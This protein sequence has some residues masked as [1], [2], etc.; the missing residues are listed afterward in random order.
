RS[1]AALAAALGGWLL[2]RLIRAF[3]LPDAWAV[4]LEPLARWVGPLE[5]VALDA[6]ELAVA[7]QWI[8]GLALAGAVAIALLLLRGFLLASKNATL[9]DRLAETSGELASVS[10]S[11]RDLVE[12][13]HEV[14]YR[15][16]L[17]GRVEWMSESA[18]RL[19][20]YAERDLGALSIADVLD[21]DHLASLRAAAQSQPGGR[22]APRRE[23]LA[24]TRDGRPLWLEMH[25]RVVQED[26]VPIGVEGVGLDVTERKVA[27]TRSAIAAELV[28]AIA[29]TSSLDGAL[30]AVLAVVGREL[31]WE[32]GEAWWADDQFDLIRSAAAWSARG[33]EGAL[34]DARKRTF[35]RGV[36]LPGRVWSQGETL[37]ARDL[38]SDPD[39]WCAR[40]AAESPYRCAV[41]IPIR[42]GTR[43]I[44]AV[45]FAGSRADGT[46]WAPVQVLD[47]I[48]REIGAVADRRRFEE[49]LKVSEAR[50][51]AV[52][53]T[54][55]DCVITAD[56]E[57]RILEWNPAAEEAFGFRRDEALGR[58]LAELIV[59]PDLRTRHLEGFRGCLDTGRR[60]LADSRIEVS[61]LRADGSRFPAELSIARI[62]VGRH[63]VFT[64]HV[65]DIT[66]R[67]A[68]DRL[69]DELVS[70]VSHELRTP[71]ASIRGFVELMLMREYPQDER[72]EFLGIVDQEI[73]RLGTLIDDFLDLQRLEA[74]GAAKY[75]MESLDLR[76]VLEH[77]ATVI[78]ATSAEHALEA[79]LGTEP[80]PVSGDRD[81]LEQAVLNLLS[82]AVKYSPDGG[83]VHLRAE[84]SGER[85]LVH[86]RDE[87]I[88]M[89]AETLDQLFTK[90]FRADNTATRGIGGT[91][92]GLALVR[93]IAEAHGGSVEACSELG[94]GSEFTLVL[95]CP[96]QR[97]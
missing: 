56:H 90:F 76:D 49:A 52:L 2:F 92:L 59:P 39:P 6:A 72:R 66:E 3:P 16:D 65:R 58:P 23:V 35:S 75:R 17:T 14:H 29:E 21:A 68:I 45:L 32:Y 55:L 13:T 22:A 30:R 7:R 33:D 9:R 83:T 42:L 19:L 8:A 80:L 24:R 82:N 18:L 89:S 38:A 15:H 53:E 11:F 84:R 81:R 57:G 94:R 20:G 95:P 47:A 97:A 85:A 25:E 79:D 77:A 51:Q 50:K 43:A 48:G 73:K 63:P 34:A 91:G 37:H 93:E 74:R 54:A 10:G 67:K 5:P 40:V 70:T 1:A 26:G 69:K 96:Q 62:D 86:V 12:R 61:A 41:G 4:P 87:G 31:H 28:R 60:P 64:A 46:H 71:L 44:G 36:G 78:G 88:G 27:E